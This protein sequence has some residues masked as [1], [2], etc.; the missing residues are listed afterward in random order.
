VWRALSQASTVLRDI[1]LVGK[2]GAAIP[3]SSLTG[4]AVMLYFSASW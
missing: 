3:T 4:K 2:A 1:L